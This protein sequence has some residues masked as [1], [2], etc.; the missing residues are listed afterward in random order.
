MMRTA[1]FNVLN[2]NYIYP[3]RSIVEHHPQKILVD[4]DKHSSHDKRDEQSV[5]NDKREI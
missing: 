4:E 2:I 1:R 3:Y 5:E